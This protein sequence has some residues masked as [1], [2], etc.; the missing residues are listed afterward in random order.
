M[1]VVAPKYL[2]RKNA[3][4]F[5]TTLIPKPVKYIVLAIPKSRLKGNDQEPIQSNATSCP[6]HETEKG[7]PQSRWHQ[8]KNTKAKSQGDS[9][10]P[11]DGHK[12]IPNKLNSI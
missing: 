12:A 3:M 9:F 11:K 7:H 8:N 5:F 4:I 6:K 2:M 1:S 10:L